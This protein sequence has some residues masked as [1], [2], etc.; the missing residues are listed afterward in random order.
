MKNLAL[1]AGINTIQWWFVTVA[2]FLG[3]PVGL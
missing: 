2:Y 1:M 3:H